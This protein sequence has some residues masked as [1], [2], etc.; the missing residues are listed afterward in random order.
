LG[1]ASWD[2]VRGDAKGLTIVAHAADG[3]GSSQVLRLHDLDGS[4][5]EVETL[6]TND[7]VLSVDATG[8]R[9]TGASEHLQALA[10]RFIEDARSVAAPTTE[11][12]QSVTPRDWCAYA[13]VTGY[14][15]CLAGFSDAAAFLCFP[16]MATCLAACPDAPSCT[17]IKTGSTQCCSKYG[18]SKKAG[19]HPCLKVSTCALYTCE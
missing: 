15:A 13:C 12:V 19:Y 17:L 9:D 8:A 7:G 4:A 14:T 5:V 6:D 1:I 11:Q 3:G 10:S 2:L 16:A 18:P